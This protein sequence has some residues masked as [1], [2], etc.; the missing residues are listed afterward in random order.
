MEANFWHQ[1]WERGEIAFHQ[2]EAN[3][4]L[5]AHVQQLQ[6]PQASRVFLP[7]CGKTLDFAWLL[8][9]G[10]QVVGAELSAIAIKELFDDLGLTPTITTAGK[11]HHYHAENIDIFVG[12]IFDL[13]AEML[14]T[15][16]AIYDRAA[17]VALP[18]DLRKQYTAHLLDISNTAAQLLITFI[19]DQTQMDGPPFSI[20]EAEV[21]H[22]YAASYQIDR[23]E[24]KALEG[25]LKG[26][27][28]IE[29]VWLLQKTH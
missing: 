22:H 29:N 15:V 16:N 13:S 3:P 8:T 28:T 23:L 26:V 12:D 27:A 6:L 18:A 17:L 2:S 7:L 19:Y 9:N 1:K 14:G 20:N 24:N 10:Y 4:F 11:M 21:N 25:G 5:V